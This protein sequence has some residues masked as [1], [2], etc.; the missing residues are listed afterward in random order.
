M[1]SKG[2]HGEGSKDTGDKDVCY[3]TY[4]ASQEGLPWEGGVASSP[5]DPG[6]LNGSDMSGELV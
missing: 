6:T 3:N 4:A 5:D 2:P 1:R